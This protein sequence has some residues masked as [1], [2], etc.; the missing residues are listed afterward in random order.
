M[1]L[2][3]QNN[4]LIISGRLLTTDGKSIYGPGTWLSG[5]SAGGSFTKRHKYY[6]NPSS[7]RSDNDSSNYQAMVFDGDGKS[8][9][10]NESYE[11]QRNIGGIHTNSTLELY[12][13]PVNGSWS[14]WG[15]WLQCTTTCGV[16]VRTHYRSC[17][18]PKPQ[19]GGL[20]CNGNFLFVDSCPNPECPG[21][22]NFET[23]YI[24]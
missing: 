10:K 6:F 8:G 23:C 14:T 9:P 1:P 12:I 18:D 24:I 11:L 22:Y 5:S 17:D 16:G 21:L 3:I 20:Y 19:F 7:I 13:Y 2:K 15:P 4:N